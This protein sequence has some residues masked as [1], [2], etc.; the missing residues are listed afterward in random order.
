MSIDLNN[1]DAVSLLFYPVFKFLTTYVFE[2]ITEHVNILNV[3]VHDVCK[4]IYSVPERQIYV[5]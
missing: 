3:P 1:S 4:T 2:N 5:K